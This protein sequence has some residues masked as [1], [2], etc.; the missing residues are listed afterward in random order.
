MLFKGTVEQIIDTFTFR[1]R[2]PYLHK[3]SSSLSYTLTED[4]PIAHICTLPNTKPNLKI[5]DVVVVGFENNDLSRPMILGHLFSENSSSSTCSPIL[6]SLEVLHD[7]KLSDN[8]YIGS[9]TPQ[10]ISCLIGVKENLQ[11]QI[12]QLK[13]EISFLR[14]DLNALKNSQ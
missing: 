1:V 6:N 14:D 3:I 13:N 10:N 8:T 4:L 12:K 11:E 7:T 9:V 2:I 5:G